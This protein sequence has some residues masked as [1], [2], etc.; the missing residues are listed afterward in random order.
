MPE[1]TERPVYVERE[2][3]APIGRDRFPLALP[4]DAEFSDSP[5]AKQASILQDARRIREQR[6]NAGKL[7]TY[8]SGGAPK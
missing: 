5:S 1:K 6:V 3:G 7:F 2:P 4:L 8:A